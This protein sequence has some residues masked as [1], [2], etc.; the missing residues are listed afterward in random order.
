MLIYVHRNNQQLGPYSAAEVR[1]QL[2]NGALSVHDH[3]WWHGRSDWIP[4]GESELMSRN[5]KEPP[6]PSR[7]RPPKD[8]RLSILAVCTLIANAGC[9]VG[10]FAAIIMG[11][12]A[13]SAMKEEPTLKGRNLAISGLIIGYVLTLI[14]VAIIVTYILLMPEFAK[15]AQEAQLRQQ[16][17]TPSTNAPDSATNAAPIN[18]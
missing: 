5:F 15:Q 13:L 2:A 16:V 7:P 3:V 1:T 10:S 9:A 14:Y 17:P 12:M 11:H 6:G 8:P 4:L 18:P